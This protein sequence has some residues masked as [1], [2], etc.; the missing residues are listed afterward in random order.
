MARTYRSIDP[1]EMTFIESQSY[2]VKAIETFS[3]CDH[4]RGL[5]MSYADIIHLN[6]KYLSDFKIHD[7][8]EI[9]QTNATYL[10][11]FH[12]SKLKF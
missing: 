1:S 2:L 12:E 4:H 7:Q 8:S 11:I 5:S 9:D 6:Q 10:K 3:R